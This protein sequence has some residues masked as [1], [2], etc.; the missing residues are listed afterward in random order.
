MRST[1]PVEKG[2]V[3]R[4][5][6]ILTE[7]ILRGIAPIIFIICIGFIFFQA[8][9][10]LRLVTQVYPPY[11]DVLDGQPVGTSV[12]TMKCA[13]DAVG[14]SYEITIV[15][16]QQW[17][18][19]QDQT[20]RGEYDGFF[21]ALHTQARDE[22]AVWSAALDVNLSYFIKRKETTAIRTEPYTRWGVKKGSGVSAQ[23][24]GKMVNITY[25]AED[26]PDLIKALADGVVDYVYMDLNIFRWSL[27]SNNISD[28]ILEHLKGSP[29]AAF[30]TTYYVLEPV[31]TQM[32]GAYISRKWANSHPGF[33][34][35]LNSAIG[36]C[37][38]KGELQ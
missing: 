4:R 17:A 18:N 28:P 25:Y 12:D 5:K 26:N 13:L 10:P 15:R 11:Q 16:G 21:G 6:L 14:H 30:E 9:Q 36:N 38:V 32:Y 1:T 31:A 7:A 34:D 19:A 24:Q 37:R 22:Y 35:R 33:M 8:P 23:M 29:D 2:R 27:A 3:M 20:R